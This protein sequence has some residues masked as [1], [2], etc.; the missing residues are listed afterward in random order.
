MA[1]CTSAANTTLGK[2]AVLL[3]RVLFYTDFVYLQSVEL[4]NRYKSSTGEVF[5]IFN[6][7][8]V[9]IIIVYQTVYFKINKVSLWLV[10]AS[11]FM[12]F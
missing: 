10:S 6:S 9:Y 12:H 7:N 8:H 5:S 3:R 4:Y 2:F 1:L 11:T